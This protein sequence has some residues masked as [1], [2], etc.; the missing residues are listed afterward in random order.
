MTTFVDE[1]TGIIR[2]IMTDQVLTNKQ[3][4]INKCLQHILSYYKEDVSQGL[5]QLQVV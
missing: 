5:I 3:L 4:N 2:Q 1:T